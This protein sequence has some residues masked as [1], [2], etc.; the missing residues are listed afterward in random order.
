[1]LIGIP[2]ICPICESS[3]VHQLHGIIHCPTCDSTGIMSS[4]EAAIWFNPNETP[5]V[6]MDI[7]KARQ[8][9]ENLQYDRLA[10][11]QRIDTWNK[12]NAFV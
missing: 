7:E 5:K 9:Q 8:H 12:I 2:S 4:F 3:Q 10:R 1:M 11:V 6:K